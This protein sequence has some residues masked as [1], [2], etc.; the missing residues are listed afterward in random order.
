VNDDPIDAQLTER[1]PKVAACL[2]EPTCDPAFL[3][4]LL[5]EPIRH[6]AI[7]IARHEGIGDAEE[8]ADGAVFGVLLAR[9]K[10]G[11]RITQWTNRGPQSLRSWLEMVIRH[12]AR[13]HQRKLAVA[14]RHLE[15]LTLTPTWRDAS[16][17]EIADLLVA[18][19]DTHELATIG[20]WKVQKRIEALC[21][22]G[23]WKKVPPTV[24]ENWLRDWESERQ[25][26]LARP[27]PPES[28]VFEGDD[29]SSRITPL[30][31]MLGMSPNTLSQRW[32]R[33]SHHLR[34]LRCL[35]ELWESR[36]TAGEN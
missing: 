11:P 14:A 30:A 5:D 6:L 1:C 23:L 8:F 25:R 13:D 36:S 33:H 4:E 17:S 16:M 29:A 34:Q 31:A 21:L 19:F 2:G 18:P 24:W 7:S 10:K 9:K 22:G 3:L 35:R 27:F 20:T 12:L 15:S 28:F 26:P 32:S